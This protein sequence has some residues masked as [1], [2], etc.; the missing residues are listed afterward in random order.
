MGVKRNLSPVKYLPQ[1][2]RD[3]LNVHVLMI[4]WLANY[5]NI[6]WR[7]NYLDFFKSLFVSLKGM[8]IDKQKSYFLCFFF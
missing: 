8:L 3:K 1:I 2:K 4:F 7:E 5:S 6:N